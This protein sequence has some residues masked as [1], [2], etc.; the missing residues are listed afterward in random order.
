VLK[1]DIQN[2]KNKKTLNKEFWSNDENSLEPEIRTSLLQIA[3]DFFADLD[4]PWATLEDVRMTGSLSNYN[5]SKYSDVDLHLVIDFSLVDEKQDLVKSYFDARKN[6]WNK[7]HDIKIKDYDVE[8]YVEDLNE[9][10]IS[11]GV[12]SVLNDE[13]LKKPTPD[14]TFENID[15]K[16]IANKIKVLL[17][18]YNE[19]I[20]KNMSIGNYEN[21]VKYAEKLS[22]KIKKMRSCGLEKDGEIS[23]EN[24]TF[25]ILRRKGLL[26]KLRSIKLDAYDKMMS[27]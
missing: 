18:F 20:I 24:F 15:E 1:T 13:W 21:T 3:E 9:P 8:I 2:L 5:W 22:E 10:S 4:I 17:S 11:S 7:D 26:D 6:L 12:Y 14:S 16:M 27:V 23:N 25:K 19:Q